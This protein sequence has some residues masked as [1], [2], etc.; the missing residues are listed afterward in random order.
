MKQSGY[1]L[2]ELIIAMAIFSMM[3][4]IISVG[5]LQLMRI[6]QSGISS[7]NT[8]QNARL[9]MEQ[10]VR[11][12]RSA[13]KAAITGATN[14]ST[15]C[16]YIASGGQEYFIRSGQLIQATLQSPSSPCDGTQI[17]AQQAITG[18]DVIVTKLNG[19]LLGL[20]G[21]ATDSLS[22]QLDLEIATG[23]GNGS[24]NGA[25]CVVGAG[26]QFCSITSL[27]SS[28]TLRGAQGAY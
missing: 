20:S 10:M 18:T 17:L 4:V 5:V 26:S 23:G 14:N 9:A 22:A 27:H 12:G 3:L 21:S 7:R 15:V 25:N 16:F 2:I 1:T 19:V 8:Q 28:V 6:Y 13:Y 24:F 11:A